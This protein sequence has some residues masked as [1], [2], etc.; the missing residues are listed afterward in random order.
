MRRW[1]TGQ[2]FRLTFVFL[3]GTVVLFGGALATWHTGHRLLAL[4][5]GVAACALL[6]IPELVWDPDDREEARWGPEGQRWSMSDAEFEEVVRGVESM[7][8][9]VRDAPS[10]RLAAD[11]FESVVADAIEELPDF[12]RAELDKNIAVV[13]TDEGESQ[14]AYGR[15][16]G[17]TAAHPNEGAKIILFRDTLIRDF[18][19]EAELRHEIAIT[20]R[21]EVAH[22][23][24]A[25]EERVRRMGL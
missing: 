8:R 2:R 18:E 4:A 22:H 6:A 21:H 24:G 10:P 16:V 20:L 12:V 13:V 9:A 25:D 14:S 3:L 23:L 19:D 1:D 15:Y 11:S 5:L 7:A 17:W